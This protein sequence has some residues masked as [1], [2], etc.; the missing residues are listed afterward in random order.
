MKRLAIILLTVFLSVFFVQA[1]WE[2]EVDYGDGTTQRTAVQ[3]TL[4]EGVSYYKYTGVAADTAGTE[5]DTVFFEIF[6]NK[7]CALT[8][9]ARVEATRTGTTDDYEISLQGKVFENDSWTSI[10]D[11][12]SQTASVSLYEPETSLVDTL[13]TNTTGTV[14]NAIPGSAD[15]F[16]RY[17]RVL[18][19][20]DGNCAVTDKLTVNYVIFKLYER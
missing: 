7:D 6:S 8:C 5:Q 1:Q 19:A 3:M 17:F 15:N 14:A 18:V 9:N 2:N 16:Y 13:D 12:A 10:N 11:Q 20:T 4:A